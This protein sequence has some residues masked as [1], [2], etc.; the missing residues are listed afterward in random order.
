MRHDETTKKK[1]LISLFLKYG[2]NVMRVYR[3][4]AILLPILLPHTFALSIPPRHVIVIGKLILDVYGHPS[5]EDPSVSVGGGGPQ[6]AFGA[7]A[8]LAVLDCYDLD[9]SCTAKL[10][11][12]TPPAQPVT[13]IGPVGNDWTHQQTLAFKSMLGPAI[14]AEPILI[15]SEDHITPRIRLW[16]DEEQNVHW[17]AEN[18]SFGSNGADGLW[19]DRPSSRD[20]VSALNE[21]SLRNE[22]ILHIIIEVGADAA[23]AGLDSAPLRDSRLLERLSFVGVE[24]VAFVDDKTGAI[25]DRDALFIVNM[26][27]SLPSLDFLCP[28]QDMDKALRRSDLYTRAT[29]VATRYGP[30]GSFLYRS[31]NIANDPIPVPTATLSTPDGKPVNPTGAGNA[32]SA[33]MT[34]MLGNGVTMTKAAAMATAVGAI[35]CEYEG[36]P[37]EWSWSLLDRVHQA[38]SEVEQKMAKSG[39]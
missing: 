15:P 14:V 31:E 8:A 23:G 12:D 34:A 26:I 3:L 4:H 13:F 20:I 22:A 19:R 18:D 9:G 29:Q 16:H 17:Y 1:T 30:K 7:A 35:V 38:A 6:A 36:L 24:P 28:D 21:Q 37:T 25:S 5:V 2:G 39:E 33:A 11:S 32:Y 27:D 10:T